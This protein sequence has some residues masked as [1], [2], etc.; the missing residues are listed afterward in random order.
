MPNIDMCLTSRIC[1][2]AVCWRNRVLCG[3]QVCYKEGRTKK[4]CPNRAVAG[5]P[6]PWGANA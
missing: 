3:H 4:R 5:G 1:E 6:A 2:R